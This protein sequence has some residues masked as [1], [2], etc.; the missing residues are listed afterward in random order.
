RTT[1]FADL[2][3]RA[4]DLVSRYERQLRALE[5]AVDDVEI[6]SAHRACRDADRH[7]TAGRLRSFHLR[8]LERMV[9]APENHRS[10]EVFIALPPGGVQAARGHRKT[11]AGSG[12]DD[13]L[14]RIAIDP[15]RRRSWRPKRRFEIRTSSK[16]GLSFRTNHP[17]HPKNASADV[18]GALVQRLLMG[19]A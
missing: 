17:L 5:L 14:R 9:C 11:R 6:R 8:R 16:T 1:S 7:L 19:P 15:R 10:H 2:D 3:D 13:R 18:F 12:D 4:C